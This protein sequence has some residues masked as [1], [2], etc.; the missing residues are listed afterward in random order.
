[1]YYRVVP[2]AHHIKET[3]WALRWKSFETNILVD[4]VRTLSTKLHSILL[5]TIHPSVTAIPLSNPA[6]ARDALD[7]AKTGQQR[8]GKRSG[9]A[10]SSSSSSDASDI[11][12]SGSDE[13]SS[14][15]DV[16]VNLGDSLQASVSSLKQDPEQLDKAITEGF[17]EIAKEEPALDPPEDS[18]TSTLKSTKPASNYGLGKFFWSSKARTENG[19]TSQLVDWAGTATPSAT[20]AVAVDVEVAASAMLKDQAANDVRM[21]SSKK[22]DAEAENLKALDKKILRELTTELTSGGFFF[23]QDYDLTSCMQA[24]WQALQTD[25]GGGVKAQHMGEEH[26]THHKSHAGHKHKSLIDISSEEPRASEPLAQRAERRFWYNRWLSR[27]LVQAGVS[28]L[29]RC[30]ACHANSGLRRRPIL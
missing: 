16:T 17:S 10:S 18:V 12:T 22:T 15:G 7:K 30:A 4:R 5:L 3:S 9:A 8:K 6:S 29:L 1:M 24:K 20:P 23:S 21:P 28:D 19:K 2:F 26:Q 25:T 27:D 11:S 14:Q 13:E